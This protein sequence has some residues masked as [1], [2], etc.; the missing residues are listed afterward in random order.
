[1]PQS[2]DIN[3]IA[4]KRFTLAQ[5]GGETVA[6]KWAG[7]DGVDYHYFV[8]DGT[9]PAA[10]FENERDAMGRLMSIAMQAAG[11]GAATVTRSDPGA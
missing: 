8:S 2:E 11:G 4:G 7:M 6:V 5:V 10:D 3:I 9:G 1:V